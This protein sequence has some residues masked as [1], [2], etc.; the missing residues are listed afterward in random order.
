MAA[1]LSPIAASA[2]TIDSLLAQT[3]DK[4]VC[5]GY[6]ENNWEIFMMDATGANLKNLTN[7]PD[8]HE[9]YPQVS[10]D[11]SKIAFVSD[12]GEGRKKI[13]SVWVMDIDGKNR[14]KVADYARQPFWA[15]NGTTLGYL[16]QEYKKFSAMDFSTKGMMFYDLE[17]GKATPH[18]N[19]KLHHLYNPG[20]S[21]D[22]KWISATVHAGM[23]F[24]HADILIE[25]NGPQVVD[26]KVHGCRPAISRDGKFL[27]WGASDHEIEIAPIDWT[28]TPP[29]LGNPLV[30]IKDKKNKIYHV[31]WAPSG[32]C[33]TLSRGVPGKGDLSKPG[34]LSAASEIVGVYATGWNIFA[35]ALEGGGTIDMG[36]APAGR[37]VAL[38]KDGHSYKESDWVAGAAGACRTD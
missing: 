35:V 34:T 9:L 22:G 37:W 29:A 19:A 38:T 11:G 23:G 7:T 36:A 28:C 13:R 16:P 15:P 12:E 31:A 5:E 27:A 8:T 6:V 2:G 18:P 33:V 10:P 30:T 26:L 24:S 32:K 20:F 1:S 3:P 21:P 25:A 17:S 4:I 14:K